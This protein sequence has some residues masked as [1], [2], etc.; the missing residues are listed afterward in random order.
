[1]PVPVK[2]TFSGARDV[3]SSRLTI[4]AEHNPRQAQQCGTC[5]RW[6]GIRQRLPYGWG[7]CRVLERETAYHGGGMCGDYEKAE[8]T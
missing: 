4:P 3:S 1:M 8:D 5:R 7:L 6:Q 2:M